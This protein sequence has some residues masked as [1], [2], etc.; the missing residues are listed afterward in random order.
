[1]K[2]LVFSVPFILLASSLSAPADS[3][4]LK[5]G[6]TLEGK[7]LRE[8]DG[9]YVIEV[10]VTKSI[11]DERVIA[12][13]DIVS[14]K[15]EKPDLTAF[16]EKISKLV[17]APDALGA[18]D[19]AQ[20][21]QT[22]E[23]FLTEHRGSS[24]SAEARKILATLKAE[25]N[26]ILAGG[27]KVGG[28]IIPPG[29]YRANAYD[30]DARIEAARITRLVDSRRLPE[31]LRAFSAF[32]ADF[33]N[34]QSRAELLPLMKRVINS[35]LAGIGQSLAT[36]DARAKQRQLGLSRMTAADRRVTESAIAE[37]TTAF[38]KRLKAEKDAK[39]GW[40][41]TDPNFKPSLD[42]T[43]NFGKQEL[44]RL[45]ASENAQAPDGGKAYRDALSKI[46]SGGEKSSASA[47]IGSARS[48]GVPHRYIDNLET[49]AKAAGL[50]P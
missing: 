32:D 30:I 47:V 36:Y 16:E 5:D 23:K 19:Y 33:R 31:A 35:Y 3:F 43:M 49:A 2:T 18:N 7:V 50:T 41:T 21:I 10:Q 42:E 25:A 13:A 6:S 14:V 27:V 48:A 17:P 37:E 22:V 24:K 1:M 12:K 9:N 20:R 44:A 39:I 15:K 38:E 11:K 34:T 45:T 28:K 29:E 8:V 26:E 40:V 4:V 46:Q